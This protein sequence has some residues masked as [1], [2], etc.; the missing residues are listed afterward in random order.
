MFEPAQFSR[1]IKELTPDTKFYWSLQ[2]GVRLTP[3]F[4]LLDILSDELLGMGEQSSTVTSVIGADGVTEERTFGTYAE[5]REVV[6]RASF[7]GTFED[8]SYRDARYLMALIRTTVG[9]SSLYRNGL[10]LA[11]VGRLGRVNASG[12]TTPYINNNFDITL[13]YK[14]IIKVDLAPVEQVEVEHHLTV[15]NNIADPDD[16]YTIS[17]ANIYTR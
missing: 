12:H 15:D 5:T 8:S 2:D 3:P 4:L 1:V 10:T 11:N 13:R 16:D 9:R 6:V 14:S 7:F 17:G